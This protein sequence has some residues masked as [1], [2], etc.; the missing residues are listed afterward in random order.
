MIFL[1]F[2]LLIWLFFKNFSSHTA[3]NTDPIFSGNEP[4]DILRDG[5][6]VDG[7]KDLESEDLIIQLDFDAIK[8]KRCFI[9]EEGKDNS[10]SFEGNAL[11]THNVHRLWHIIR[12]RAHK[13][14]NMYAFIFHK[15]CS[16]SMMLLSTIAS[17]QQRQIFHQTYPICSHKELQNV[18]QLLEWNVSAS[19]HWKLI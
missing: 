4:I 8:T 6:K 11:C 18:I 9:S 15:L 12:M 13:N 19:R 14:V 17:H 10:I 1:W 3:L 7:D 5:V 16:Y 2:Q